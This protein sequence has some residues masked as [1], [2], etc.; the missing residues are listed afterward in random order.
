MSVK[1]MQS[2]WKRAT[3]GQLC[4]K[5]QIEVFS[6]TTDFKSQKLTPDRLSAISAPNDR[7]RYSPMNRSP[8]PCPTQRSQQLEADSAD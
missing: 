4:E 1:R 8:A 2:N 6:Q 7:T 3:T 5:L